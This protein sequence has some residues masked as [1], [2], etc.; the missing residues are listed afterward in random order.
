MPHSQKV[1]M[2]V[3]FYNH[4]GQVSGAERMLLMILARLD[5]R[6]FDPLL[7]C[8]E[9]GPLRKMATNLGVPVESVPGLEARFTWRVD[10]LLRYLTSFLLVI[11]QLRRKVVSTRPDLIHANSIRAGLVATAATLGMG[12]R[13]LWHLHDLLPRHPLSTGVRI[14]AFLCART[15]MIAVSMAVKANFAGALK[16]LKSRISVV[17]NAIEVDRFQ[18][19]QIARQQ[20]RDELNLSEQQPVIGI[21]GQLTP[22]K[23]QLELIRAF[24][25]VV[26]QSPKAIL[27]VAG[28]PLFNRDH[29]YE[30]LLKDT[31]RQL[32][33]DDR[34]RLLGARND[35][36]AIMQALDLLVINSSAEPFGLVALEA[37]ACGTPVLA[38]ACDGLT[39]IIEHGVDGWL[40]PTGDEE[41]LV[42]SI[43]SLSRQPALR[44]QLEEQGKKHVASRFSADRY[45][46]E[47]QALYHSSAE[48]KSKATAAGSL[49][50][51]AGEATKF[52][53]LAEQ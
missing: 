28:A 4:T 40:V 22:R 25:K 39:E 30:Q 9:Q 35:V 6:D 23:G 24:A 14:F 26:A 42:A 34:V 45:V 37:M 11:R 33:I 12:T 48:S 41:T 29:E 3:L 10:R 16:G 15:R 50:G 52:A 44:T 46:A 7:I 49:K 27:L 38:A 20:V 2:K 1:L 51:S 19:D 21:V 5:Q 53:E 36:A 32:G 8:P 17:L 43:V 13:V 18:P 47:L 31:V